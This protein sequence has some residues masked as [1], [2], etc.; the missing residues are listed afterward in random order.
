MP[1]NRSFVKVLKVMLKPK[2]HRDT[3][4]LL[5]LMYKPRYFRFSFFRLVQQSA[6]MA[7]PFIQGR[8]SRANTKDIKLSR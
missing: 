3:L 6:Y 2:T 7:A 4:T 5:F 8:S 1:T